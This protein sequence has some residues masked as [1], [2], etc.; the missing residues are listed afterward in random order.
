MNDTDA[1][2]ARQT[3]GDRDQWDRVERDLGR[4]GAAARRADAAIRNARYCGTDPS[5]YG[6]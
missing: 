1:R 3:V 4:G 2:I 5:W 6:Y